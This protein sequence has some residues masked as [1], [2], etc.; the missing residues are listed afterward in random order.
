MSNGSKILLAGAA[1]AAVVLVAVW[2]LDVDVSGD[3]ELPRVTSEFEVIGGEMPDVD[4]DTVDVDVNEK[5][6]NVP[7]PTDVDITTEDK[8][9]PYPSFEVTP[10]END[11]VAEQDDFDDMSDE[12]AVDEE[13]V[14]EEDF[15]EDSEVAK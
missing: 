15:M 5:H 11:G 2:A 8:E 10:L 12:D 3:A 9:V 6:L 13:D 14:S 7:V 4:V 1:V